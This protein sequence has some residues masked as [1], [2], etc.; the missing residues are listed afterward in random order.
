MRLLLVEDSAVLRASLA[1]QLRA[2]QWS[3]DEA[4][5]GRGAL[6]HLARYPYDVVVLDLTL[7]GLDGLEV[8][9]GL[10][11]GG[12]AVRVLVLSARDRVADRVEAL[13][14]GADDYLVKPFAF[15]ELL[16]RLQALMRRQVD[17]GQP[18]LAVAGLH[19]EPR[20]RLARVNGEPLPLTPKEYALLE[21]LLRSR[22]V[23]QPRELLFERIYDSR[24]E[25]SDKVIEVL[26][27]T[28]R[29]KLAAAGLP[30][31]IKTRRGFGYLV[32]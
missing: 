16:S 23:A 29:A 3:V 28:L 11:A 25:S 24:S 31:L 18:V 26:V 1:A 2:Q 6:A 21:A 9:S 19:V 14:R 20:T 5:D 4:G 13:N 30:D 7:P 27:S 17:P 10:R 8:L 32:E 15:Q 22:G 12:S